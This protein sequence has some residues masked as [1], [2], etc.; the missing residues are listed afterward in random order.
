MLKDSDIKEE[1]EIYDVGDIDK[2][3]KKLLS[4]SGICF[5]Y[6]LHEMKDGISNIILCFPDVLIEKQKTEQEVY[7]YIDERVRTKVTI[8]KKY[9]FPVKTKKEF[10]NKMRNYCKNDYVVKGRYTYN[11][12]EVVSFSS[13]SFSCDNINNGH[14]I[15]LTIYTREK[16]RECFINELNELQRVYEQTLNDYL[17]GIFN[18]SVDIDELYNNELSRLLDFYDE[19]DD[20]DEILKSLSIKPKTYIRKY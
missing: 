6:L 12:V 7:S 14:F 18:I 16:F 15:D 9:Y 19:L 8:E 11:D 17:N 3:E 4:Y 20:K 2:N 13:Y 10:L 5:S 1:I